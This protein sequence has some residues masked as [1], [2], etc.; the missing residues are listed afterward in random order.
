MRG[1]QYSAQALVVCHI[2]ELTVFDRVNV[3][4]LTFYRNGLIEAR[5]RLR[6]ISMEGQEK[7]TSS[8]TQQCL[9]VSEILENI[10][11][12]C[13][14]QTLSALARTCTTFTEEALDSLWRVQVD[15]RRLVKCLPTRLWKGGSTNLVRDSF[16][17]RVLR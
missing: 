16:G 12:S 6:P 9:A 15:L 11:A 10:V 2:G 1:V 14:K 5:A 4:R 17:A 7:D 8:P 3:H 13:T